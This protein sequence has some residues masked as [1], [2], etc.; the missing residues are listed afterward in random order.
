MQVNE[1]NA[2]IY[3]TLAQTGDYLTFDEL[4][5][6]LVK[7]AEGW[8][9]AIRRSYLRG[10]LGRMIHAGQVI[11]DPHTAKYRITDDVNLF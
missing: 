9:D 7:P 4:D 5:R 3:R 10:E 11:R 2:W 1:L 6:M 8:S